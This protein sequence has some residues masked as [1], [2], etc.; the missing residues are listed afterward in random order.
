M[1]TNLLIVLFLL[2][3]QVVSAAN[4]VLINGIY[5]LLDSSKKEAEVTKGPNSDVSIF[6]TIMFYNLTYN[7]INNKE[8]LWHI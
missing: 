4:G 5:Y 3:T 2:L 1:K 7:S 6:G 8:V